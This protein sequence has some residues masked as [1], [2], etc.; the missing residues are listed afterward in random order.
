MG[1]FPFIKDQDIILGQKKRSGLNGNVGQGSSL[2]KKIKG[3]FEY[4]GHDMVIF[5]SERISLHYISY[6]SF[7][8]M[9]CRGMEC[10]ENPL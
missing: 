4:I 7:V 2:L 8:D 3:Q 5:G 10:I 1:Y 6:G 9:H